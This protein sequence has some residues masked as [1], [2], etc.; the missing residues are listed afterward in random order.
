M[1]QVQKK[2]L[3]SL[4]TDFYCKFIAHISTME[5]YKLSYGEQV[6]VSISSTH[7]VVWWNYDKDLEIEADT[8]SFIENFS[9]EIEEVTFGNLKVTYF[10]IGTALDAT[11]FEIYIANAYEVI[12]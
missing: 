11:V 10:G 5:H 6:K 7:I 4:I 8:K 3:E 12:E 9:K 1:K 2:D